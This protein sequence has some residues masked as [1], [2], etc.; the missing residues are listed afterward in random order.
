MKVLPTLYHQCLNNVDLHDHVISDSV[1]NN[2]LLSEFEIIAY[3][4]KTFGVRIGE[5]LGS[6]GSDITDS[7]DIIIRGEKGSASRVLHC[8]EIASF[9]DQ[10]KRLPNLPIFSIKYITLWRWLKSR[11]LYEVKR[12]NINRSVTHQYRY[13][14]ISEFNRVTQN[15]KITADCIGHRSKKTTRRYLSKE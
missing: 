6:F 12:G 13:K 15:D 5:L 2:I 14:K 9:L 11:G 3:I 1:S 4:L 7:F 10:R 8:P